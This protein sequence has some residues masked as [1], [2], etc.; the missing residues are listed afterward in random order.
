MQAVLT[1]QHQQYL[2]KRETIDQVNRYYH[3]MKHFAALL[4]SHDAADGESAADDGAPA[5]RFE[6][7]LATYSPFVETGCPIVDVLVGE[8]VQYCSEHGI[9]LVPF[10]DARSLRDMD[11]LDLCTLFGNAFDNAIEA[12]EQLV[13]PDG[14]EIRAKLGVRGGFTV[15]TIENPY[16]EPSATEE[17]GAVCPDGDAV[18]GAARRTRRHGHRGYGIPNMRRMVEAHGGS[19]SLQTDG[20]VF[21]LTAVLPLDSAVADAG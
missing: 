15:F 6:E 8:K 18:E 3:D 12:V 2:I 9:H 20:G 10:M 11:P 14:R 13:D 17:A 5:R 16:V 21:R 1:A 19:L 4:G 7:G